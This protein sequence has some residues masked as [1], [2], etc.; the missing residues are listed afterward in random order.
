MFKQYW[1]LAGYKYEKIT[2][3]LSTQELA[4]TKVQTNYLKCAV[5]DYLV[6]HKTV[7]VSFNC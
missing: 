6:E 4:L 7:V 1:W 5:V 3:Y 2:E